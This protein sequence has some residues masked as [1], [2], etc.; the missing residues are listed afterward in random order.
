MALG[1]A[2]VGAVCYQQCDASG[3]NPRAMFLCRPFA[4]MPDAT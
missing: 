3:F 2:K 4:P 1:L